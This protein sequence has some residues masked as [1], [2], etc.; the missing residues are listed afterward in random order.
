MNL[1]II[2]LWI[3]AAAICG[4]AMAGDRTTY[5]DVERT[6]NNLKAL[7]SPPPKPY[8][9]LTQEYY[10]REEAGRRS[11]MREPVYTTCYPVGNQVQC[12][13]R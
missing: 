2:L 13:T 5:Q 1:R 8:R 12:V 11:L 10:E 4:Q 9:P 6:L 3:G 7:E